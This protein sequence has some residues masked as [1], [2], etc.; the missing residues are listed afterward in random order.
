DLVQVGHGLA[1]LGAGIVAIIILQVFFRLPH[2]VLDQ[3]LVGRVHGILEQL[4][5]AGISLLLLLLLRLA[6]GVAEG[7]HLVGEIV[8]AVDNFLELLFEIDLGHIQLLGLKLVGGFFQ[9]ALLVVDFAGSALHLVQAGPRIHEL[10]QIVQALLGV[11]LVCLGLVERA[12]F[13]WRL[14]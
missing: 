3:P 13:L 10:D 2:L 5:G 12:F 6:H 9:F 1:L 11:F 8:L 4:G 7:V 14:G